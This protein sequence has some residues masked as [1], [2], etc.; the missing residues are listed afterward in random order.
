[1][2]NTVAV[3]KSS[4]AVRVAATGATRGKLN[5]RKDRVCERDSSKRI[6]SAGSSDEIDVV[7]EGRDSLDDAAENHCRQHPAHSTTCPPTGPRHNQSSREVYT[8]RSLAS[9]PRHVFAD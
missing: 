2:P 1:M 8:T 9:L 7:E 3:K 6:T 5:S 4:N